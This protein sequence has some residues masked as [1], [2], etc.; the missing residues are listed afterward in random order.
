[1]TA[2]TWVNQK[3]TK[4]QIINIKYANSRTESFS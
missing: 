4:I 1:M 3:V 2:L